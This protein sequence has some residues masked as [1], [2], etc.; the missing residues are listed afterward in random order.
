MSIYEIWW[1]SETG[2]KIERVYGYFVLTPQSVKLF[3]SIL[4][5][6]LTLIVIVQ[7]TTCTLEKGLGV[8]TQKS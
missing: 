3:I 7:L 4:T 1:W 2:W 5:R 6:T 8:S